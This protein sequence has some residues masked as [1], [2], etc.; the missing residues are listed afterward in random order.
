MLGTII[1]VSKCKALLLVNL[2]R[3]P[4]P[5]AVATAADAHSR[6]AQIAMNF[7]TSLYSTWDAA[8]FLISHWAKFL[9]WRSQVC[10]AVSRQSK[11]LLSSVR[12]EAFESRRTLFIP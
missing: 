8:S 1:L 10:F 2:F 9:F 5:R 11:L 7:I 3:D 4:M 6:R 12:V